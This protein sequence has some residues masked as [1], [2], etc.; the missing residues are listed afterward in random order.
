MIE[1]ISYSYF[2]NKKLIVCGFYAFVGYELKRMYEKLLEH[3]CHE[4]TQS[5]SFPK[6]K[7]VCNKDRNK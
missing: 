3:L 6:R 2:R 5:I 1:N 7:S 4:V